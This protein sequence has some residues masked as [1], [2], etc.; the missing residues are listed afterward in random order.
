MTAPLRRYLLNHEIAIE[1]RRIAHFATK[2][3]C[4]H[5]VSGLPPDNDDEHTKNCNELKRQ[6]MALAMN[7]KLAALQAPVRPAP[8]PPA[9]NLNV[10]D[11]YK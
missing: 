9:A 10:E 7:I 8:A 4:R 6:I 5:D 2:T 3:C 11:R 1:A